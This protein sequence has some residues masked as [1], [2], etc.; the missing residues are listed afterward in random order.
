VEELRAEYD[1]LHALS[2][3]RPRVTWEEG[4]ERTIRWYAENREQWIGRVD[5][6]EESPAR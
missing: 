3:W 5:W 1:K 2:K 6:H 4:I